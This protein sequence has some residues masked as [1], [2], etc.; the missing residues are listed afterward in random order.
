M[1]R[2]EKIAEVENVCRLCQAVDHAFDS[3]ERVMCCTI[4]SPMWTA[5][6]NL[7]TALIKQTAKLI[8][9]EGCWLEWFIFENDY[10][11]KG[12]EAGLKSWKRL[13]RTHTAKQLVRI[14]EA[15]R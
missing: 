8:G 7:Q 1:T 5:V 11:R 14:I 4:D 9:D 12:F 3:A 13:R 15:T 6:F 10:G 2:E